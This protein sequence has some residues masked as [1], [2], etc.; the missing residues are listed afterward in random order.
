MIQSS[1]CV[2]RGI[3]NNF[4]QKVS[5]SFFK[6]CFVKYDFLILNIRESQGIEMVIKFDFDQ[7]FI[8]L[9]KNGF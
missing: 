8:M 4:I 3:N 5:K 9:E 6:F 1:V 7:I 2:F